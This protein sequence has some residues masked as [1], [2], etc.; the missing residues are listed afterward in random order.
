M[1]F[2][3]WCVVRLPFVHLY[4]YDDID[5]LSKHKMCELITFGLFLL[6]F[7]CLLVY[8]YLLN[9]VPSMRMNHICLVCFNICLLVYLYIRFY[10]VAVK[11][12]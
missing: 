5:N 11:I 2:V 9:C 6:V 7:V 10:C 12:V 3:C 1:Y 4:I 8:L